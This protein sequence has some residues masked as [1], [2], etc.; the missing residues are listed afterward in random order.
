M[1]NVSADDRSTLTNKR[2][3]RRAELSKKNVSSDFAAREIKVRRMGKWGGGERE[4]G[5]ELSDSFSTGLSRQTIRF[6]T[7]SFRHVRSVFYFSNAFRFVSARQDARA[8]VCVVSVHG[9]ARVGR[10]TRRR[11]DRTL[12]KYDGFREIDFSMVPRGG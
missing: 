6:D 7:K 11:G 8:T 9:R 3:E 1:E 2:N 4:I 12:T 5:E 10:S